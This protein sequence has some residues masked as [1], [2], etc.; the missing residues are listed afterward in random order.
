MTNRRAFLFGA[1]SLIAS[2][3]IVRAESL[4]KLFVPKPEFIPYL[5]PPGTWQQFIS[6]AYDDRIVRIVA[7]N[8]ALMQRMV[9]TGRV[10]RVE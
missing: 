2:P 10:R 5:P 4:M 9:A 3:A 7:S 6:A 8:N 1:T